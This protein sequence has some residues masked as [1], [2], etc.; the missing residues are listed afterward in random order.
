MPLE[1]RHKNDASLGFVRPAGAQAHVVRSR[2]HVEVGKSTPQHAVSNDNSMHACGLVSVHGL[3]VQLHKPLLTWLTRTFKVPRHAVLSTAPVL[4]ARGLAK[5]PFLHKDHTVVSLALAMLGQQQ[6]RPTAKRLCATKP[7]VHWIAH[8]DGQFRKYSY[9]HVP[10]LYMLASV[11]QAGLEQVAI[12][13]S[14]AMTGILK[15]RSP[16]GETPL[17]HMHNASG[18]SLC[19]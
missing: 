5:A 3:Q 7:E 15:E 16:R 17:L 9:H 12:E 4:V 14:T 6:Q 2:A 18:L 13:T 10:T 1:R 19:S 8:E 11:N